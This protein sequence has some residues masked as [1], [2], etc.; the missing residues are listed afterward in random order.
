MD[1]FLVYVPAFLA[2]LTVLVFVH[3]L[4]H[5][6]VAR[7]CGVHVEV[8]SIGFGPELFGWTDRAKTRWKFSAVPL[9]GYVKMFGEG[10]YS[11]GSESGQPLTEEEKAVSFTH[12]SLGQRAAIVVAG[13]AANYVFAI[14]VLSILFMSFGQVDRAA[15]VS[16]VTPGSAAEQAGMQV[17]DQFVQI[18]GSEIERFRDVAQIVRLHPGESLEMIIL[19]DGQKITM[20][21]MPGV[22]EMKDVSGHSHKIGFLGVRSGAGKPRT[23]GPFQSVW[24]A[25]KETIEITGFTLT[26]VGQIIVGKREVKELGGPLRIGQLSGDHARQGFL[27]FISLMTMLSINLGLINLFPVPMLDGGHLLFYGIEAIRGKPL[28]EKAQEF[29]LRIGLVLVLGLMLFVTIND[30]VSLS[31]LEFVK[32]LLT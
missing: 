18:D 16:E 24:A 13:P 3:E 6:W 12:K 2:L 30:L 29:G 19:R 5:Y 14:L 21:V 1:F 27:S 11:G 22:K 20:N 26:A 8:F 10:A 9:G 7:R 25:T 15:T 32:N 31:V 17:G 23:L 4:G 28:G